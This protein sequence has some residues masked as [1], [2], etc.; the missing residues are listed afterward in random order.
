M[1]LLFVLEYPLKRLKGLGELAPHTGPGCTE[2]QF[3][4]QDIVDW[5]CVR[6]LR[7][8]GTSFTIKFLKVQGGT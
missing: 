3:L 5:V 1:T 6:D 2:N 7:V 4:M 8:Q